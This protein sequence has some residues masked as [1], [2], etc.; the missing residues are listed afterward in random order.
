[1]APVGLAHFLTLSVILF[2]VGL[3]GVLTRRN[4]VA[5]LMSLE[6]MFNAV[7]I[8]LV[9]FARFMGN[10]VAASGQMFALFVVA[11]AGAEATIGVAIVLALYRNFRHINVDEVDLLKW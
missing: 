6:L 3:Y 10:E 7:N 5:I 4:A 2:C 8:S 1:M 11:V 9:G